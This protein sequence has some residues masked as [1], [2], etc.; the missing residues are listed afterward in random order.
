MASPRIEFAS[1]TLENIIRYIIHLLVGLSIGVCKNK[2]LIPIA[3]A[4]TDAL[5]PVNFG[6]KLINT[7]FYV[8]PVIYSGPERSF[9][10]DAP[11]T[12]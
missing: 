2:Y 11:W 5:F 10:E 9:L 1:Y 3:D 6:E 4:L 8:K 7:P 12:H